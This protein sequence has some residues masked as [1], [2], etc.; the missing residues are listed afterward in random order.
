MLVGWRRS[1]SYHLNQEV[2]FAK[3]EAEGD[4]RRVREGRGMARRNQVEASGSYQSQVIRTSCG[5]GEEG[6]ETNRKTNSGGSGPSAGNGRVDMEGAE[7]SGQDARA[8]C[9]GT[10][11]G[12]LQEASSS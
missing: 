12:S 4:E 6:V 10:L 2:V 7:G 9:P 5:E 1:F 8:P 11:R 3:A